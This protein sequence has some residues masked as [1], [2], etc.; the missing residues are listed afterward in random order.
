MKSDKELIAQIR[1]AK[2]YADNMLN[3]KPSKSGRVLILFLVFITSLMVNIVIYLVSPE[4]YSNNLW[5]PTIF[6]I[7]IGVFFNVIL[8]SSRE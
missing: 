5:I 8:R 2:D 7:A 6:A 3:K 1:E 4:F